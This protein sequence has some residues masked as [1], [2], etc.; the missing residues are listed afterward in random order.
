MKRGLSSLY[1]HHHSRSSNSTTYPWF[2]VVQ[3]SAGDEDTDGPC[4]ALSFGT[5]LNEANQNILLQLITHMNMFV[6][7][8]G[9]FR[10]SGNKG[11]MEQ[12]V[13]GLE[14]GAF[15]NVILEASYNANDFASVLK[16]YFSELPEPLLLKRHLNAYLQAAGTLCASHFIFR[17]LSFFS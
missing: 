15:G 6:S 1:R 11:R 4:S 10:K 12:L 13:K 17:N 2:Q 3:T 8:E 7:R 16:Q 9:L 14:E 5:P